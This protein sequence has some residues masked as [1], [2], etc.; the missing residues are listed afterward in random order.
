[1][2]FTMGNSN[3]PLVEALLKFNA[4]NPVSFH[5][6]GHKGGSLSGL[7]SDLRSVLRYDLT[8]LT[9]LDDL[10][11]PDGAIDEA[12]RKLSSFYGSDQSFFLVNGS[13]V[14]NLAMIYA[15][16]GVGDTIIV[17]RNAH[18]SV[19]HAIEL[20]GARPVLVAPGWDQTTKTAG[21]MTVVQIRE[22]LVAYPDAKAVV[23]THPTYYGTTGEGLEEMIK[24]CHTYGVP[25]LVDEAHGAHFAVGKPFPRS[26]LDMGADVVV[27]SAHKTLPAMTMASF[28]HVRSDLVS[29]ERVAHYLQML[30]SSSPSYVLMASL[31]DARA[32]IETY[33]GDDKVL[34][35]ERRLAFI[36]RLA[37]IP[38]LQVIG[39][40][41]PL[42]LIIRVKDCSGFELQRELEV[43]GIYAELADP[44]Q[45]L[46]VL[47]L[48]KVGTDYPFEEIAKRMESAVTRLHL[49]RE[50]R[51]VLEMPLLNEGISYLTYTARQMVQME[52]EWI[53]YDEAVGRV[54]A[55]SIIPYP[56]GIPLLIGGEKI[57]DGHIQTLMN[58]LQ[59]GAKFQGAIRV[60]EGQI[61]VV[62]EG[63]EE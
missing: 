33:D 29:T 20:T 46:F 39:S 47:P 35:I 8:E 44:Y 2:K 25:V 34:F 14:G 52:T 23:V 41:D 51:N 48:L 54:V 60:D 56:P 55:A 24:A 63:T 37:T 62:K 18:K 42:K 43:E 26:A 12:Q 10:H 28:L 30:Q 16:C 5:V 15:T 17:Q 32:Y 22:A 4:A 13:T 3:R 50:K 1:M 61:V 49:V 59:M 9:G 21:L 19:F 53:S 38:G 45:V 7:P 6:P 27:H 36:E 11:E 40:N 31:D 58:L 57:G